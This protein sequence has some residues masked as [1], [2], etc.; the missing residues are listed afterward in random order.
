MEKN[1]SNPNLDEHIRI[2]DLNCKAFSELIDKIMSEKLKVFAKTINSQP[3]NRSEFWTRKQTAERLN[4][5]LPTLRTWTKSGRVR[6]Y[7]IGGRVLYKS[8]EIGQALH[9]QPKNITR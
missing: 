1:P 5:T 3:P 6:G 4:I 7:V 2:I 9:E 8:D